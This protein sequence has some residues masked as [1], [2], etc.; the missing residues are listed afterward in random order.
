MYPRS[1]A[2]D[3][4]RFPFPSFIFK[5]QGTREHLPQGFLMKTESLYCY[6]YKSIS[7]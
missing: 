4:V 7:R 6:N 2:A 3:R 1:H 5:T